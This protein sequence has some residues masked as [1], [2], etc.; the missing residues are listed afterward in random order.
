M[1]IIIRR[2]YKKRLWLP[3]FS[4]LL[5]VSYYGERGLVSRTT[6]TGKVFVYVKLS[7]FCLS[8]FYISFPFILIF[9]CL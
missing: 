6:L 9:F 4:W 3:L 1:K 5:N 8:N 7:Y 2:Q